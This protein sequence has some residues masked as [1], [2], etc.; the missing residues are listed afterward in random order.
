MENEGFNER[1]EKIFALQVELK[2][3][4][5]H[6]TQRMDTR[7]EEIRELATRVSALE[8]RMAVNDL[9]T[10]KNSSWFDYVFKGVMT[11]VAGYVA[12]RVNLK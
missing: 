4:M 1:L 8:T 12:V 5:K 9:Q 2:N 11:L 10:K 7:A 3:D 6:L